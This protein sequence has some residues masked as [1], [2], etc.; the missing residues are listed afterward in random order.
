MFIVVIFSFMNF[1]MA[2]SII[3]FLDTDHAKSQAME[4]HVSNHRKKKI[5]LKQITFTTTAVMGAI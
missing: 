1:L 5:M 2:F 3:L 4:P